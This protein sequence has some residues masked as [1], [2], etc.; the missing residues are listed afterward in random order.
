MSTKSRKK[1]HWDAAAYLRD[2]I[3]VLMWPGLW[4]AQGKS[5]FT[6]RYLHFV[7][8]VP[9]M[10]SAFL[11][12]AR[13]WHF[14]QRMSVIGAAIKTFPAF[15]STK[16]DCERQRPFPKCD[17]V[18]RPF[19]C[20][21][22]LGRI[23][24]FRTFHLAVIYVN[25]IVDGPRQPHYPVDVFFYECYHS[26]CSMSFVFSV[27]SLRQVNLWPNYTGNTFR[28]DGSAP[29]AIYFHFSSSRNDIQWCLDQL[30]LIHV[31]VGCQMKVTRFDGPFHFQTIAEK[32]QRL[33]QSCDSSAASV[34]NSKWRNH[35]S[36]IENLM[37][38]SF[39]MRNFIQV[40]TIASYLICASCSARVSNLMRYFLQCA[41]CTLIGLQLSVKYVFSCRIS[42]V[43]SSGRY[44]SRRD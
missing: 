42:T 31:T 26:R 8:C 17:R 19:T 30:A 4:P 24:R 27:S 20:V 44:N 18:C 12:Q 43:T 28:C 39:S 7:L 40:H 10:G 16:I 21:F 25:S 6:C 38:I 1:S 33:E 15:T 2:P 41:F 32:C 34:C 13:A 29:S 14:N 9:A 11:F 35:T 5:T 22:F 37:V 3:C 23:F 36:S